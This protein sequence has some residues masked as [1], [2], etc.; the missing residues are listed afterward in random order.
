MVITTLTKVKVIFKGCPFYDEPR[1]DDWTQLSL[2]IEKD[3][4]FA[5]LISATS[6]FDRDVFYVT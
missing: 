2:T 1:D 4:G 6:Y 3:L 5:K